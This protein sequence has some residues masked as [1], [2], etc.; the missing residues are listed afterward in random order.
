MGC[1]RDV[2]FVLHL[3][4]DKMNLHINMGDTLMML[5]HI[6][7]VIL[8]SDNTQFVCFNLRMHVLKI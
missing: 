4:I 3:N 1:P 8:V 5:S 2:I 6:L 7:L